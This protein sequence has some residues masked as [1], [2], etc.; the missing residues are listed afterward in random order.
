MK[1]KEELAR[2]ERERAERERAERERAERERT[3]RGEDDTS[4]TT[5]DQFPASGNGVG[6]ESGFS[7]GHSHST[8]TQPGKGADTVIDMLDKSDGESDKDEEG[9]KEKKKKE[10]KKKEGLGNQ[11]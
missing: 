11:P 2:K 5:T 1:E 3:E 7:S 10:K 4:S 6:S 9:E 8:G